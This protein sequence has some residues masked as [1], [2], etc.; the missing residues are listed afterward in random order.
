MKTRRRDPEP[1]L[2]P[3]RS[4]VVLSDDA[5][6]N[7]YQILSEQT[8]NS[9]FVLPMVKANGYGHGAS[10]CVG[11]LSEA[12]QLY[13]FGVAALEEG[14]EVRQS[15]RGR[16]RGRVVVFSGGEPF[17]NEVGEYCEYFGLDPVLSSLEGLKNF[18]KGEWASRLTYHVKFNTGMNRLGI[19]M[20]SLAVV[21]Q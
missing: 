12:P 3:L 4:Q 15:V 5:L 6:L 17:T 9:C 20:E 18:L 14:R 13:G 2:P 7:N 1:K 21:E 8:A 16:F 10:F 11:V 19:P